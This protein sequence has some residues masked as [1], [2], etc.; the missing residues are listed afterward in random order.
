MKIPTLFLS[1]CLALSTVQPSAGQ[2]DAPTGSDPFA[3][4]EQGEYD[5]ALSGFRSLMTEDTGNLLYEYWTARCLLELGRELDEAI[6]ML[7]RANA[8]GI[9]KDAVFY[10]GLAHFRNY[11]FGEARTRFQEF[12]AVA[13][14]KERK[15]YRV[16]DY[17]AR[18]RMAEEMTRTYFHYDV[19]NVTFISLEDSSQYSQVRT[20]SGSLGTRPREISPGLELEGGLAD[21]MFIPE[22]P[23]RGSYAYFAASS[24]EGEGGTDL[25][26]V[27]RLGLAR[28][29]R[30]ELLD[31]LSTDMDEI[32]PYFD[33]I[34]QNLYF[35]SKG[36]PGM[37]GFDLFS[38]HYDTQRDKWTEPVSMG[39][40]INGVTDDVLV[41][42][43]ADLGMVLF[44]TDREGTD[45]TYT[46]YRVHF[47]EPRRNTRPGDFE[48]LHDIASL[49]GVANMLLAELRE[50]E[51]KDGELMDAGDESLTLSDP[52]RSES[53]VSGMDLDP[54][55]SV[56]LLAEALEHQ[57]RAD[58]LKDLAVLARGEIRLSEDPN[59]RWVWQKQ[60]MLWEKRSRDESEKAN[61]LF[62][63]VEA[64]QVRE[65]TASAVN[66]PESI[67]L[68]REEEGLRVY[69]YAQAGDQSAEKKLTVAA[70]VTTAVTVSDPV[71]ESGE[72][73][74]PHTNRFEILNAS[75]YNKD[76]PIPMDMPVPGGIFYS[77]QLGVFKQPVEPGTFG[78][79]A[80][81]IGETI[82]ERGIVKYYAGKF[83]DYEEAAAALTQIRELGYADAFIVAWFEGTRISTMKA[84]QLE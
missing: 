21:L 56:Y 59:D 53:V 20:R 82:E 31:A 51:E 46:V 57:V 40:P 55:G 32:M 17:I 49:G 58:S 64:E 67:E 60:I 52:G 38:S 83:S 73:P 44:F 8:S 66:P 9:E 62:A 34:N 33:P 28:W 24:K 19:S 15:R 63:M 45:S 69:S 80:P 26:R 54:V 3:L 68:E 39:F 22:Q 7:Y 61:Q 16:E 36:L 4:F 77:V 37:G 23:E 79:I 30:P 70:P 65:L 10:L 50:L 27:K 29:S 6:E 81:V 76:L 75:P 35:A 5:G 25:Y 12:A 84:K 72:K 71:R 78:G 42:P 13:G 14:R 11:N 48:Q 74:D 47:S 2:H 43:G 18:T 1:L 41:L